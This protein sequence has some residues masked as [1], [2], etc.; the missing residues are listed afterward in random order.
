[1]QGPSS[2]LVSVIL[3]ANF[4]ILFPLSNMHMVANFFNMA[5]SLIGMCIF[6][7]SLF[8]AAVAD[9]SCFTIVTVHHS[10]HKIFVHK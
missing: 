5:F 10:P 3:L 9:A 8:V 4:Q 2:C 6:V 7:F 1:M